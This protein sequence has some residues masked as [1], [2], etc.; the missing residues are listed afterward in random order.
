[1][2]STTSV[3][4]FGLGAM[5]IALANKFQE[6]GAKVTVWNRSPEKAKG[7]VEKGARLASSIAEGFEASNLI[8]ICLLDNKAVNQ[9]I[10]QA[11]PSLRGRIVVN[12]TNGTPEHARET[13]KL[14]LSNGAQYIHGGI[15]ATP[16]MVGSPAAV[17]L[18]SGSAETYQS[19]EK[20]LAV[21]GAGKYLGTDVGT[22]SLYDLALLSGMYGLFSGFTHSVSLIRSE[23]NKKPVADFLSLL[24]PWL[25]AMTGYLHVL[26]Q[27]IDKNDYTSLGS[28]IAMQ[29]PA[30]ENIVQASKHQGVNP[31]LIRPIQRLFQQALAKGRGNDDLSVLVNFTT[32]KEE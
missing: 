3:S 9:T 16:D 22:A 10:N 18:Y 7:L 28:S 17:L 13:G 14:V 23:D 25:S 31:D 30:L 29:V 2:S 12:L 4:V 32:E 5:G 27:Q 8:V 26:A 20:D 1:M 21:F 15:M 24:V 19:V 11:L 6:S